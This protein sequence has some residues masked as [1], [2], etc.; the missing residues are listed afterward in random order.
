MT[1]SV[2]GVKD[3]RKLK[4]CVIRSY[5]RDNQLWKDIK[6][7]KCLRFMDNVYWIEINNVDL[8]RRVFRME[9]RAQNLKDSVMQK[10]RHN[11]FYIETTIDDELSIE[12]NYGKGEHFKDEWFKDT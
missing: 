1:F 10:Q 9:V 8:K 7:A 11:V 3:Y 2:G 5:N 4:G 12:G 6:A